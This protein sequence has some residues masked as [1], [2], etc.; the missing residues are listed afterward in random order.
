MLVA[1]HHY[2][3]VD[4]IAHKMF[5]IKIAVNNLG[6]AGSSLPILSPRPFALAGGRYY[7]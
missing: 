7:N 2:H 1:E 6:K 3:I 4:T 5:S